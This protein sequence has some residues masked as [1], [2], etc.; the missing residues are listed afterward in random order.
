[1]FKRTGVGENKKERDKPLP[2]PAPPEL[3]RVPRTDYQGPNLCLTQHAVEKVSLLFTE[4]PDG[5]Y[6]VLGI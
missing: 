4:S 5:T 3:N 1:M 6:V 2:R